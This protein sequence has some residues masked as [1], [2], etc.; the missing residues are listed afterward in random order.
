MLLEEEMSPNYYDFQNKL[1]FDLFSCPRTKE[2]IEVTKEGFSLGALSNHDCFTTAL[3][4]HVRML[5]DEQARCSPQDE[6]KTANDCFG[7]RNKESDYL[8]VKELIKERCEQLAR[9]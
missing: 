6:T 3:V 4:I 8:V 1:S 5:Y 7:N 9:L 2:E